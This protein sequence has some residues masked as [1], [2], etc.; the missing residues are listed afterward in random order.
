MLESIGRDAGDRWIGGLSG[1]MYTTQWHNFQ[2]NGPSRFVAGVKAP[3][4]ENHVVV[5]AASLSWTVELV[6]H[7]RSW[8]AGAQG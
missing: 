3:D 5:G 2:P 7:Q 6:A 4:Q 8:K 1:R